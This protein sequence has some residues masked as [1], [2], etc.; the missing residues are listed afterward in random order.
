MGLDCFAGFCATVGGPVLNEPCPAGQCSYT[1]TDFLAPPLP[2][3]FCDQTKTVHVCATIS[4]SA[5]VGATCDNIGSLCSYP[6][7]CSIPA[8]ATSATFSCQKVGAVANGSPCGSP[9]D[10]VVGSACA[11]S[12]TATS[13]VC[14]PMT[15]V[16]CTTTTNCGRGL[17]CGCTGGALVCTATAG[18]FD[19]CNPTSIGSMISALGPMGQLFF[20]CDAQ[21]TALLGVCPNMECMGSSEAAMT[22][23]IVA[24]LVADLYC[25]F[26]CS[27]SDFATQL[28]NSAQVGPLPQID[29][30]ARTIA[31]APP[32]CTATGSATIITNCD[33]YNAGHPTGP[34][35][36]TVTMVY[37]GLS[38]AY[39]TGASTSSTVNA[40][41]ASDAYAAGG[42]VVTASTCTPA[43]ATTPSTSTFTVTVTLPSPGAAETYKAGFTG[44]VSGTSTTGVSS[45]PVS[46][47]DNASVAPSFNAASSSA[48][49]NTTP[50]AP[51]KGAA[52]AL[53]PVLSLAV[54]LAAAI[55]A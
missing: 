46:A 38:C 33:T 31:I 2:S 37:N 40:A 10:C 52:S 53:V 17:S 8:G 16:A 51:K 9:C 28:V 36:V 49:V 42:A 35:T 13:A 50:P 20:N 34:T 30:K 25:C 4:Y 1:I 14:T 19:Y 22:N 44:A 41:V 11:I 26:L 7:T 12:G 32:I 54:V 29:C 21:L 15:G 45:L 23:P 47:R 55:M 5:T 48:I 6:L 24:P 43:T 27:P 39:V 18:T 3:L